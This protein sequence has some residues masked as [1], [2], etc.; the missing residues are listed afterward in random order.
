MDRRVAVLL[1]LLL[2]SAILL[3]LAA[4][5]FAVF[6]FDLKITHELQEEQSPIFAAVMH[7]VSAIGEPLFETALIVTVTAIFVVWRQWREAVFVLATVSSVVLTSLIKII[8]GR[9]RPPLFPV[10]PADFFRFI[11]QYSFPSGH[12]LFFVVFFGFMGY[13]AWLHLAGRVRV[14]VIAFCSV[15]ILLIG[16]SR[17]YLGAHWASDVIGSYVIGGLWLFILVLAYQLAV[18]RSSARTG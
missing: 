18:H 16:P 13:L 8:V 3:S 12:V 4:H 7:M 5:V 10:N 17:V 2:A 15:L 14:L 1:F 6:P 11:N 9:P